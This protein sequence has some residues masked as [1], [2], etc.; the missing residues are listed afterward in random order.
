M[1]RP[2]AHSGHGQ[3][4]LPGEERRRSQR[5]MIRTPVTL[6]L[7]VAG[8]ELT[9][10][11]ETAAVNDHGAMLLCSRSLTANTQFELQNDR[12]KQHLPCRVT[13]SPQDSPEGFLIPVEF[14]APSPGFWQISFPPTDWKPLDD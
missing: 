4:V 9:I 1:T 10:R 13:R 5:V 2:R 3:Q 8:Q 14:D 7:T 6:K 12:T 11:A